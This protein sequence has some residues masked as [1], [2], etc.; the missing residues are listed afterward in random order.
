MRRAARC[1]AWWGEANDGMCNEGRRGRGR[2]HKKA[3]YH[4]LHGGPWQSDVASSGGRM[5]SHSRW[6]VGGGYG[7]RERLSSACQKTRESLGLRIRSDVPCRLFRFSPLLRSHREPAPDTATPA[8]A[9]HG[10]TSGWLWRFRLIS[11]LPIEARS[12][13][14]P[15]LPLSF[16]LFLPTF[17]GR[18]QQS[19]CLFA[20]A[21]LTCSLCSPPWLARRV[22]R[23]IPSPFSLH[24]LTPSLEVFLFYVTSLVSPT[25]PIRSPP[26]AVTST[27]LSP[28]PGFLS[29]VKSDSPV[30]VALL[31]LLPSPFLFPPLFS[32]SKPDTFAA[33]RVAMIRSQWV[34]PPTASA[35]APT[36]SPGAS[37]PSVPAKL[38]A[39]SGKAVAGGPKAQAGGAGAGA[40]GDAAAEER[41]P[42]HMRAAKAREDY[43]RAP[44][45][46]PPTDG[47]PITVFRVPLGGGVGP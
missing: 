37:G 5:R 7:T 44:R 15:S 20:R 1:E 35:P 9:A 14:P 36:P 23:P 28:L 6:V 18:L 31:P 33:D 2:R 34:D 11:T 27:P 21:F 3:E 10:E 45:E 19:P 4:P 29:G 12:P 8:D 22:I 13:Y 30:A 43:L 41:P 26:V 25:P 40:P 46:C 39:G 17:A 24:L 32:Q 42:R 47:P 16:P 38:P